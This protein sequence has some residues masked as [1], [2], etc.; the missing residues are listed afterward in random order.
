[1]GSQFPEIKNLKVHH[2]DLDEN[3]GHIENLDLLLDLYYKGNFR[4][5]IDAD[6][7]LGKKGFL[8]V[9]G[10]SVIL[11]QNKNHFLLFLIL[12]SNIYQD[13]LDCSSLENHTHTGLCR[14]SVIHSWI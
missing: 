13:W 8:S 14:L 3:E 5:A 12:Q 4:L 9:K 2:A 11:F 1:L 6:M 10:S 7:V